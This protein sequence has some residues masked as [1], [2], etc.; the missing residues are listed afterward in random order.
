MACS[1]LR[2]TQK[3]KSHLCCECKAI[4]CCCLFK[5]WSWSG[6]YIAFVMFAFLRQS[7]SSSQPCF[8]IEGFRAELCAYT[9][10]HTHTH[11]HTHTHMHTHTHIHT[12]IHTHTYTHTHTHTCMHTHRDIHT[13]TCTHTCTKFKSTFHTIDYI[14]HRVINFTNLF[15]IKVLCVCKVKL[16]VFR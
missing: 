16:G 3:L 13:H 2:R 6:V 4:K 8:C 9:H 12:H 10:T 15:P 5:A 7:T 14:Y 11:A 1:G